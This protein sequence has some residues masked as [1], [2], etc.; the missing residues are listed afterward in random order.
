MRFFSREPAAYAV[1]GLGRF[2]SALANSLIKG[3][4]NVILVDKDADRVKEFRS[5]TDYAYVMKHFDQEAFEEVGVGECE[6]AIICIGENL[7]ANILATLY[8]LN[9]KV[10]RVIAKANTHDQGMILEKMGAEVVYPERDQGNQLAK[11]LMNQKVTDYF[12]IS[13]NLE[14]VQIAVPPAFVGHKILDLKIRPRWHINIV[15]II[16]LNQTYEEIDPQYIF[17]D[18]DIIVAV[19][20]TSNVRRFQDFVR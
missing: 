7:D 13:S 12:K 17:Q 4:A 5:L 18:G 15:A 10:P 9:L 2:G 14:L 19:G 1:I 11:E 6:V 3:G 20:S 8:C 16:S